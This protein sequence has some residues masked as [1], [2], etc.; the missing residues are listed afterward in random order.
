M[1]CLPPSDLKWPGR[2]NTPHHQ[3]I[4]STIH[5]KAGLCTAWSYRLGFQSIAWDMREREGEWEGG[6]SCSESKWEEIWVNPSLFSSPYWP[7]SVWPQRG[8]WATGW[9]GKS[10]DNHANFLFCGHVLSP[11]PLTH[12]GEM[13]PSPL[14]EGHLCF[15]SIFNKANGIFLFIAVTALYKYAISGH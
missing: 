8:L 14:S 9:Q 15:C 13:S 2:N 10:D 3:H 12:S 7:L 5:R 11:V 6:W 1:H 4:Q